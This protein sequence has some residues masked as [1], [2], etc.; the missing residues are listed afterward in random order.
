[1]LQPFL[2]CLV[3]GDALPP[4]AMIVVDR[5]TL[6][7]VEDRLRVESEW[8]GLETIDRSYRDC[9]RPLLG[10]RTRRRPFGGHWRTRI[11]DR[12]HQPL[13]LKVARQSAAHRVEPQQE[14]GS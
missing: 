1:M 6:P 8:V 7:N 4:C 3:N 9:I 2:Q 10:R 13:K 14:S 5:I 11:V 12:A